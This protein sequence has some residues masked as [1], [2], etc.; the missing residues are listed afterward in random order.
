M[1]SFSQ[2]KT[3][4]WIL[5]LVGSSLCAQPPNPPPSPIATPPP[6]PYD[7]GGGMK[8]PTFSQASAE[9]SHWMTLIDQAQYPGSWLDAGPL[10]QDVITQEEW[11]AAM[12][13]IRRPLG[14]PR[15]RKV[16]GGSTTEVLP[17]GTRGNF[18]TVIY[19]TDFS[20]K[21]GVTEIVTL[22]MVQYDQWRVISY[23]LK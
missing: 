20:G 10:L 13:G 12:Q 3:R 1:I 23:S 6:N 5:L 7:S 9:A 17:R 4:F 16:V 21:S 22:M 19:N 11:V 15:A 14:I 2:I 8:S 18:V